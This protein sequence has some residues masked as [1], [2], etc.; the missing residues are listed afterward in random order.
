MTGIKRGLPAEASSEP[1]KLHLKR[2]KNVGLLACQRDT[3]AGF[4]LEDDD[5]DD[6]DLANAMLPA[7]VEDLPPP[8][9]DESKHLKCQD[10]CKKFDASF[11]HKKFDVSVC[12]GCKCDEK[13]ELCTKTEAKNKYLLKDCDLDLRKPVLKFVLRKNPHNDH[14]GQMK[15]YYKAHIIDR[16]KEIW[17][18]LEKIEEEKEKRLDNKERTKQKRFEK[19]IKEL[20]RAVRTSTWQKVEQTHEHDYDSDNEQYDEESDE[21]SKT[22]K[23][24]G[25][26]LKYEKM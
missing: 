21:Y 7:L 3:G 26:V 25:H 2:D 9:L 20:R 10:C 16:A 19:K 22:C 4:F 24:C 13:H 15:L 23:S 5:D 1:A 8:T 6:D 18:S 17:G 12:D 11:L 14:W